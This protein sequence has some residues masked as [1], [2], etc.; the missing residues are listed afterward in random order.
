MSRPEDRS[1]DY[2]PFDALRGLLDATRK[3][4]DN[5]AGDSQR[6]RLVTIFNKFPAGDREMLLNFL[7]RE[8]NYKQ[9]EKT[10]G[11]VTGVGFRPNPKARFYVRVIDEEKVV[12]LEEP[13]ADHDRI[14][15]ASLRAMRMVH[16]VIRP[17]YARWKAATLDALRALE[18]EERET[19][20]QFNRDFLSMVEEVSDTAK[21]AT[22]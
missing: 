10:M 14:V 22:G 2:N 21:A 7:E 18:P 3:V 6:E 16:N 11:N 4:V 8:A 15:L 20:A 12:P 13:A 19:I 1:S 5:L 17:I 9:L